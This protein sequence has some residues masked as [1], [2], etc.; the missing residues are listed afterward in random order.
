MNVLKATGVT[1]RFGGLV[2]VNSYDFEIEE[3]AKQQLLEGL[4]DID[5]TLKYECSN[6]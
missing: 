3:G 6:S 1:K 5:Q 2:A 4:D